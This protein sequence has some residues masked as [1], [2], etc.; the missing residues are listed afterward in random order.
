MTISELASATV[1]KAKTFRG[2]SIFPIFTDSV[3]NSDFEIA[4]DQLEIGELA[5]ASVPDLVVHNP[6]IKPVIIPAGKI[7]SG[8]RQTRTVNVSIVVY[9]GATIVIP[10]SCVERGRWGGAPKFRDSNRMASKRVRLQKEMSVAANILGF[11]SKYSDQG[12]VWAAIDSEL[13]ERNVF[14]PTSN[15]LDADNHLDREHDRQKVIKKFLHNGP[16]EGQTGVVVSYGAQISGLEIFPSPQ[17][18]DQYWE[19]IIRSAVL[20][21]PLGAARPATLSKVKK[22]VD[23]VATARATTS[24]GVGGG[25]ELHI[26]HPELVGQALVVDGK[27]LHANAFAYCN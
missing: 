24:P 7:L 20:D 11:G 21:S 25:T 8:G 4:T 1:G 10:V 6:T 23:T 26:Q 19:A 17:A 3:A 22:F 13:H 5:S 15:F 16:E 2:T 9:P 14:A 27:L 18:L 12:R